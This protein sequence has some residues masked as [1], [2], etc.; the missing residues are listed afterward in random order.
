[1]V[2][3]EIVLV[4]TAQRDAILTNDF[5]NS[6]NDNELLATPN[7]SKSKAFYDISDMTAPSTLSLTAV[8]KINSRSNSLST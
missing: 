1:M 4:E 5:L 8:S 6:S 2:E 3:L 7:V